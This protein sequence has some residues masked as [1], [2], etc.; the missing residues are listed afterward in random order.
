MNDDF[1]AARCVTLA[2]A[3]PPVGEQLADMTHPLA[4]AS[5]APHL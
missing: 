5:T 3:L 1:A 2:I 4:L